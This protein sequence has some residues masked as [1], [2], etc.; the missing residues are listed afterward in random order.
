MRRY[1]VTSIRPEGVPEDPARCIEEISRRA[2]FGR[3]YSQC[4]RPRGHG[5]DGLYCRQHARRAETAL[6]LHPPADAPASGR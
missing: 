2:A 4:G 6:R 5:P 1:A 3:D